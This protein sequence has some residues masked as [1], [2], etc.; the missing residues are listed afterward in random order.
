[1][2]NIAVVYPPGKEP[3]IFTTN[4]AIVAVSGKE[5]AVVAANGKEQARGNQDLAK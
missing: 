1:V 2:S 5:L 3:A 4:L